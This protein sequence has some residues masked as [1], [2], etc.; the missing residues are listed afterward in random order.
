MNRGKKL[1]RNLVIIVTFLLIFYYFGGYYISKQQC[2]MESLRG[3]YSTETNREIMELRYGNYI[4]T[5]MADENDEKVAII[6]TNKKGFLYRNGNSTT[7]ISI[8]KE[9][10]MTISGIGSS[11]RMV[12]FIYRNDKSIDR[13]EA[14]LKNGEIYTITE[15]HEDYAGYVRESINLDGATYKAYNAAGELVGEELYY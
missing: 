2:V 3:L 14:V 7:G 10:C 11:E 12:V 9:K 13:V 1:V 15:W 6:G 4:A 8:D 5:L